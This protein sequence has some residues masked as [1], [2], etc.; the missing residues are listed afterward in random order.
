MS[1]S[2]RPGRNRHPD[3][4]DDRSWQSRR[5]ALS[6]YSWYYVL[7]SLMFGAVLVPFVLAIYR[8]ISGGGFGDDSRP[9]G[10]PVGSF[11]SILAYSLVAYL[12]FYVLTSILS[13]SQFLP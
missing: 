3:A 10:L 9:L 2:V 5:D 6:T 13:V 7:V 4:G 8:G 11:R 1:R 12:G